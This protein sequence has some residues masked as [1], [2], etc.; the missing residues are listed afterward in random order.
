[1]KYITGFRHCLY[2]DEVFHVAIYHD[3]DIDTKYI[4]LT[5]LG[6]L[7]VKTGFMWDGI[8]GPTLQ[9]KKT[10]SP[11]CMDDSPYWLIRNGYLLFSTWKVAD[12]EF[13]R[14]CLMKGIF[15]IRA[16]WLYRGLSLARGT[17]AHPDKR[18]K[19]LIAP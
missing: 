16:W 8:S 13:K 7:T 6:V 12:L 9:T 3:E 14:Y 4:R 10:K 15:R 2:E 17:A 18:K 11:S 1:M 5:T 19:V